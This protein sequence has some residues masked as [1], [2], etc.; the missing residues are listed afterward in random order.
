MKKQKTKDVI[1]SGK[2]KTAVAKASIKEGPGITR[3]N[4]RPISRFNFFQQLYL[5]EPFELAKPIL[6][7][8]LK[9]INIRVNVHG[10]G[11]ESQVEAA[12]LAIARGL[13]SYFKNQ[14]LRKA[15]LSY[16]RAL[17]VA[18]TRRK[19]MRKPNDSRARASRQKSY[20]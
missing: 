19:E 13:V 17:V 16:D 7:D 5:S 10:G 4:D 18:D 9:N 12:R 2:R 3:I 15:F 20:R 11:Q 1:V 6:G 8:A 14:T